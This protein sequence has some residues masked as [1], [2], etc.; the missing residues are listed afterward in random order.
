M[1]G[2]AGGDNLLGE[3]LRARRELLDPTELDLP[4]YGRRRVP[5]L[6][7]EELAQLAGVSRHYYARLE[8]G[9]DRNPSTV[10]LDAIARALQLDADARAHLLLLAAPEP[11]RRRSAYRPE[12][13]RPGLTALVESWTEQPAVV[14]GRHRDVLAANDLAVAL[15]SGFAPGRN[16]L[17][18]VFLDPAARDIYLEWS[19]IAHGAVASVRSTVGSELDDLRLTELVGELSLK[20]EEFRAMW[21]RHDVHERTDGTKRFNNQ[22]VGEITL[23]YQA[24]SVTGAVRQT[25]YIFSAAPFSSAAQSLTLLAGIAQRD[26]VPPDARHLSDRSYRRG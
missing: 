20:S 12:K 9:R 22:L 6:R 1:P 3:F 13:V 8:Q 14:I 4:S 7:R 25:L 5:G 26:G 18:D 24:L 16:L 23:N 10:V 11:Q 2:H 15:N 19:V 17:R 21:A